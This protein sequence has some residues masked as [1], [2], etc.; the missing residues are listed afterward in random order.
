MKDLK[1]Y[2]FFKSH[3]SLN[4]AILILSIVSNGIYSYC[5]TSFLIHVF[6]NQLQTYSNTCYSW[7]KMCFFPNTKSW[8]NPKS[9]PKNMSQSNPYRTN[10]IHN[11]NPAFQEGSW[12]NP[13]LNPIQN[14]IDQY[15]LPLSPNW[16][17]SLTGKT[18]TKNL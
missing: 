18:L 7:L 14:I 10:P 6:F 16:K 12:S 13:I 5:L 4:I 11:Q 2:P 15:S 9:S 17:Y 3:S 1:R 8:R